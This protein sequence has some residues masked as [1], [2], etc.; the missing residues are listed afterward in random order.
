MDRIAQS[1]TITR[2]DAFRWGTRAMIQA[3]VPDPARD[4]AVLMGHVTGE[5]PCSVLL[6]RAA[7]FGEMEA[8]RFE[9]L[10]GRRCCREPISHLL[11]SREFRSLEFKI[12]RDVLTPRPETET[13][14]DL[15]EKYLKSLSGPT[16]V[17]D[18]GTGP[19]TIAV[20]LAVSVPS[21]NVVAV[22]ISQ[23]ALKIA[24]FN[25]RR[26]EVRERI[27]FAQM[28]LTFSL[29]SASRFDL[30]ISNPPYIRDDEYGS[31]PPEVRYGDPR[32]ALLAGPEGT[33]FYEPVALGAGRLLKTGGKLMVEVGKGMDKQ[34]SRIVEKCGYSEIEV[35]SDLAGIDRVVSGRFVG[36]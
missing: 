5:D 14:L 20:S 24:S 28:D 8:L 9:T 29:R 22:D 21:C 6:H 23:A 31:L 3:G 32:C 1:R 11:G 34:V 26:H 19:G 30:V 33:E 25:A 15:A 10:V 4:A 36:A 13:L 27:H 35:A 18:V 2:Q 12:T 17:V 7:S 16:R